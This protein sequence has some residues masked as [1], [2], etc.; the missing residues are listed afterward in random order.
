MP[1]YSPVLP[2]TLDKI[3]GYAMNKNIKDVVKQNF[4]MLLLTSPGERIMIP[5]FGVGLRRFLFEP[6]DRQQFGR[7][8]RRIIDQVDTY[9]PFLTI[10]DISFLTSDESPQLGSNTLSI[11]VKYSIPS[12]NT[13]DEINLKLEGT[14]L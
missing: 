11:S 9:L 8:E 5:N 13:I 3:D 2:L 10:S 7:V 6:L 4:R 14:Q 1:R 12:V